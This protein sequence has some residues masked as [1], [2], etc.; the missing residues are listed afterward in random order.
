[1]V[2]I[3]L[4]RTSQHVT[5]NYIYYAT[6]GMDDVFIRRDLFH[7]KYKPDHNKLEEFYR[8][9]KLLCK[10]RNSQQNFFD[11]IRSFSRDKTDICVKYKTN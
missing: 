3:H 9:I 11:L 4:L 10:I 1:M 7:G 5:Q 8:D 6:L 2:D